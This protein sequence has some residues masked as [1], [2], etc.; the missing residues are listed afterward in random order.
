MGIIFKNDQKLRVFDSQTSQSIYNCQ[1][2]NTLSKKGDM[3]KLKPILAVQ[4]ALC[5]SLD[6]YHF[7]KSGDLS[8]YPCYE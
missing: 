2:L 1:K 4:L 7:F 8:K 6:P 5:F 3:V